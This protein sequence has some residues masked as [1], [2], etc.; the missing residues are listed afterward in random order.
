MIFQFTPVLSGKDRWILPYIDHGFI[1]SVRSPPT[2]AALKKLK[3]PPE[4]MCDSGGFQIYKSKVGILNGNQTNRVMVLSGAGNQR[5][6]GYQI[7]D[8]IC[9]CKMY[10]SLN[11]KYGFT[12]DYPIVDGSIEEYND[13]LTKSYECAGTMFDCRPRLCPDT[14][15]LIPLQFSTRKQLQ[16]YY[17][18]MSR[19]CPDGYGFPVRGITSWGYLQRIVYT[20]VFLHHKGVQIVHML[21]SSKPEIIVIG[22]VTAGLSMFNRLTFDSSTWDTARNVPPRYI[23]P[24]DLTQKDIR[25]LGRFEAELPKSLIAELGFG[26]KK[27]PRSYF[28][29]LI[30]LCNII[31]IN[32]YT[33]EMFELA[34]DLEELKWFISSHPRFS[35]TK[36]LLI[37]AI[38]VLHLG[39]IHGYSFVENHFDWIWY[40]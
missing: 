40:S 35:R 7:L 11:I 20:L 27:L 30:P 9:L 38:E 28:Y 3:H 39:F 15:L 6:E 13:H 5:C 25:N 24:E 10:G 29:K 33:E 22:A 2:E 32:H 17:D 37:D 8:P 4:L 21:G 18:E 26:K 36:D 34:K 16:N 12:L 1:N 14:N 19:L 23:S 31:T